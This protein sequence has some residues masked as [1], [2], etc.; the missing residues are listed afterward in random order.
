MT[1]FSNCDQRTILGSRSWCNWTLLPNIEVSQT[2]WA[3]T[4]RN[5]LLYLEAIVSEEFYRPWHPEQILLPSLHRI[6]GKSEYHSSSKHLP[7]GKEFQT[8][9]LGAAVGFDL[10]FQFVGF[11]IPQ[12]AQFRFA[13]EPVLFMRKGQ[14][15]VRVIRDMAQLHLGVASLALDRFH[16]AGLSFRAM[17]WHW[18]GIEKI[19]STRLIWLYEILL[20]YLSPFIL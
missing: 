7:I 1:A 16:D 20:C 18:G 4:K 14:R 10:E 15:T 17:R 2:S 9:A 8:T 5:I 12:Y 11:D 19:G 6:W 13:F 3:Q